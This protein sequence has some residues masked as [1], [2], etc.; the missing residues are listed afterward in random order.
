MFG[1]DSISAGWL[2]RQ[3]ARILALLLVVPLA[4]AST[5]PQTPQDQSEHVQQQTPATNATT[6]QPGLPNEP[7]NHALPQNAGAQSPNAQTAPA[8]QTPT[9]A[10]V[11]TAAAPAETAVGTAVSRPA[12]A[13]IAPAKQKR[14]RTFV[15]RMALVIG[16]AVAVGTVVG[17]S[18][19]SRNRP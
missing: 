15:I 8:Q 17:L 18:K 7:Q 6:T 4:Q 3:V 5:M 1:S 10:P 2:Q 12:G 16:A 14:R 9:P 13:A 19:A 11:G